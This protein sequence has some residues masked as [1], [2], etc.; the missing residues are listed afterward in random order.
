M[1]ALSTKT[2]ELRSGRPRLFYGNYAYYLDRIE[3]ESAEGINAPEPVQETARDYDSPAA[4]QMVDSVP[5]LPRSIL[6]KAGE[7]SPL[8]AAE[9]REQEKQRQ[10][11]IRRLERQEA[12]ILKD[13]E[14]LEVAKSQLEEEL[15][16]PDIYSSG[17]KAK[18]VKLKLDETTAAL[19]I[20]TREWELSAAEL[21]KTQM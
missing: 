7:Q 4:I 10:A 18:A 13:L 15:S 19:E 20:K 5:S 2:L 9:R 6:V 11:I 14:K 12:A 1:E 3:R 16:R 8:S 17:E 21:E